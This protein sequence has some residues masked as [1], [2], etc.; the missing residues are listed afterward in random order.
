MTRVSAG[1]V[2]A[3]RSAA[4]LMAPAW[5]TVRN[6][7]RSLRLSNIA[8]VPAARVAEPSSPI[9]IYGGRTRS[10]DASGQ[11]DV[12]SRVSFTDER[13]R[14]CDRVPA[15]ASG[16][17]SKSPMPQRHAVFPNRH[18]FS[19]SG[20]P[21][22]LP[23]SNRHA[24][25]GAGRGAGDAPDVAIAALTWHKCYGGATFRRIPGGSKAGPHRPHG[26]SCGA[27]ARVAE[28]G[29]PQRAQWA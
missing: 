22:W 23:R 8:P 26:V 15:G 21:T 16:S 17:R 9:G 10:F 13:R 5:A 11:L 3:S 18:F 29:D 12:G 7:T 2:M 6:R 24:A 4:I 19:G 27:C 1:C 25:R 14:G 20:D 28:R